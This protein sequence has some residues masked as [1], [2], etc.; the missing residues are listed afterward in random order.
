MKA[1][2]GTQ[3]ITPWGLSR[4]RAADYLELTKP[5]LSL[6]VL[7][8]TFVGFCT[9]TAGPLPLLRLLHTL[10]GTALM[11]GGA[12]AFNMYTE[13]GRDALM[14]RTARRPLAAGR[15]PSGQALLFAFLISVGGLVY[16]YLLVNH[17]TSLLSAIIFACYLFL[18][19]P[20]KTRTWLCT[21]V[22]AVPGALPIVM[23]W[24]A[25][26]G[27][28][29][30]GSWIL[31]AI[32]FCWQ[33]PHFYAIG[34]MYRDDYAR[35]G[36]PVLS[37]VDMDGR[38]TGQQAV[39]FI[40]ILT[41]ISLIPSCTGLA[42]HLYLVGATLLGLAFL[43]FGVHFARG[44]DRMSARRLFL[45]SAFYLPALLILLVMEKLTR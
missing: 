41:L 30:F 16:L 3:S 29:S 22:G 42:G 10:I 35:A 31:F 28:L 27:T 8:T 25:A 43:A 26:N 13:Q 15:I 23:G 17:L 21:V 11:S 1:D 24:A 39:A 45:A 14:Q 5:K 20:L 44:R 38:R 9:A 19:T 32:V 6:L 7:F 34:W 33:I 40:S 36:L 18:Y 4:A 37:V 12:S 2:P